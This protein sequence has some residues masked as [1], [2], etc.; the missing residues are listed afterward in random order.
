MDGTI[1][2]LRLR[3]NDVKAYAKRAQLLDANTAAEWSVVE[4]RA[5]EM[6]DALGLV[7]AATVIP[8]TPPPGVVEPA[9]GS[10]A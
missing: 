7:D 2:D 5:D 6:Y 9:P 3:V 8:E 10:E 4:N 1:G